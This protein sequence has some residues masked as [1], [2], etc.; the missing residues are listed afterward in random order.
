MKLLTAAASRLVAALGGFRLTRLW[1]FT[2]MC[3]LLG[4]IP[5]HLVMVAIHGWSNFASMWTG[6]RD[7]KPIALK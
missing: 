5:G 4:F 1:H 6:S 3:A 2:A 7:D